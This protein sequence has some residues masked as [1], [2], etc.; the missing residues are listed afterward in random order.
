MG[1][2]PTIDLSHLAVTRGLVGYWMGG[3]QGV[4]AL[5][6]VRDLSSKGK[7]GTLVANA[8]VNGDGFQSIG[9]LGQVSLPDWD[10]SVSNGLSFCAQFK[11]N[12]LTLGRIFNC[13][14]ANTGGV[15]IF[16]HQ[17]LLHYRFGDGSACVEITVPFTDITNW[18]SIVLTWDGANIV[19]YLNSVQN[20]TAAATTY[21]N[22]AYGTIGAYGTSQRWDGQIDDV[23]IYNRALSAA[24][25]RAIYDN[26]K[27]RHQNA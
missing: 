15:S 23:R 3:V 5:G 8:Y 13:D 18:Y 16:W 9:Q 12:S 10:S 19:S 24:E 4:P 14:S 17:N 7:D 22:C 20:G 21:G 26:T 25:V 2:T 6:T 1:M 27:W 11:L